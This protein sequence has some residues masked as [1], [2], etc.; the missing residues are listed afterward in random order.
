MFSEESAAVLICTAL[1]L[2]W[3]YFKSTLPFIST[4]WV[5]F[6]IFVVF[7]RQLWSTAEDLTG[8]VP[9]PSRIILTTILC[10]YLFARDKSNPESHGGED[11]DGTLDNT[12]QTSSW[13]DLKPRF[14]PAKTT[15][16]R[17]FPKKHSFSY[18]YLLVGIPVGW[19]GT[20]N[21]LLCIDLPSTVP[22][23]S[24]F[25]R[26]WFGIQAGHYL[27]RGNGNLGLRGK[28]QA[29]LKSQVG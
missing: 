17:L 21:S 27:D 19:R 7:R 24:V 5:A 15:H 25:R 29:Y 8:R 11:L 10:Y 12:D 14:F 18:S 13:S 16:T 2:Q 20:I 22:K 1:S 28:L 23:K 3:L 6:F 4:Y 26:S 9:W